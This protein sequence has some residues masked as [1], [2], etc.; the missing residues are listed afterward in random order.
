MLLFDLHHDPRCTTDTWTKDPERGDLLKTR[1]RSFISLSQALLY[2]N[3]VYPRPST[4]AG[5]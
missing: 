2:E 3:R 4:P 5:R 1:V